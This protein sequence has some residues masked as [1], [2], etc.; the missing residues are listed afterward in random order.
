M[1]SATIANPAELAER[2]IEEKVVLVDRSG[3]PRGEKFLVFFNPPVVNRQLGI[4]RSYVSMSPRDRRH[5]A[6]KPTCR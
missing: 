3:A 4:R 2:L 1:S 5:P 6:A